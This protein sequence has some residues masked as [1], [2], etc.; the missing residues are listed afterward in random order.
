MKVQS[1][2]IKV[3]VAAVALAACRA[4]FFRLDQ[5]LE[6]GWLPFL[7]LLPVMAAPSLAPHLLPLDENGSALLTELGLVLEGVAA[8]F[9]LSAFALRWHHALLRPG[10]P[11]LSRSHFLRAWL[12]FLVYALLF[13]ALTAGP[14]LLLAAAGIEP[15]QPGEI[16]AAPDP[17]AFAAAALGIAAA[18]VM[19]RLSLLFPAAAYGEPLGL[20]EAWRA[21]AG[22]T[23]RIFAAL[24]LVILPIMLLASLLLNASLGMAFQVGDETP[25]ALT[26]VLPLVVFGLV[27]NF[28]VVA[29]GAAVFSDFYR[30]LVLRQPGLGQPGR[31]R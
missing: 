18:L 5:V 17:R 8:L 30:R 29:L 12:R 9:C 2:R 27:L 3:P 11:S 4:V 21:M 14:L 16:A 26:V 20:V 24:F 25:P 31:A 10:A 1:V 22:N 28:L 6:L 7:V 15:G 23:W 19:A 13:Y